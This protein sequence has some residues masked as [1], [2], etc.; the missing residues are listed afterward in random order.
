METIYLIQ[1]PR[2]RNPQIQKLTCMV[3]LIWKMHIVEYY[4]GF[5]EDC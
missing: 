2:Q 3:S 5:V 4:R 1:I